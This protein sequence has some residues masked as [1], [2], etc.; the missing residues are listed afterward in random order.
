VSKMFL[1]PHYYTIS[2]VGVLFLRTFPLFTNIILLYSV[3]AI[4]RYMSLYISPSFL[5]FVDL[6]SSGSCWMIACLLYFI[7]VVDPLFSS[8]C[9]LRLL[10]FHLGDRETV[11]ICS[12][13][14]LRI[15]TAV[16]LKIVN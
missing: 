12:I 13:N 7:S 2:P 16:R 15:L 14:F 9:G 11:F 5:F 1:C 6:F 4:A 3:F 10:Y 8:L